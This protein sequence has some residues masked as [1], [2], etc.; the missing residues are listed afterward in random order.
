M[1]RG[2]IDVDALGE[3]PTVA[4]FSSEEDV[5]FLR[6]LCEKIYR[7]MPNENS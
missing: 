6:G 5:G 7:Y 3:F 1:L 2:E 4:G